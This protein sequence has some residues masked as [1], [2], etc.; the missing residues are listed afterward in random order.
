M[1]SRY[2][3]AAGAE[4]IDYMTLRAAAVANLH[5]NQDS[6]K[7]PSEE[8]ESSWKIILCLCHARYVELFQNSAV[9]KFGR[10]SPPMRS[11]K[12][13]RSLK[14]PKICR[15]LPTQGVNDKP[16]YHA[17]NRVPRWG[18]FAAPENK[19]A[20]LCA[21]RK[22]Q[23]ARQKRRFSLIWSKSCSA[24]GSFGTRDCTRRWR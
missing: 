13:D 1:D 10:L 9:K 21:Y 15:G 16:D 22:M 12:T 5:S 2:Q 23:T 14:A 8:K 17:L 4:L 11:L 19:F 6:I 18:Q 3:E 24:V 7:L 20:G